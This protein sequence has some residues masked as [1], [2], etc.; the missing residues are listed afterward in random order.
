MND[1]KV[2]EQSP[3]IEEQ[4]PVT[5]APD[6]EQEDEQLSQPG[7]QDVVSREEF[8]RAVNELRGVQGKQ[9]KLEH[10]FSTQFERTARELGVE[11]TDEQ[12]LELRLR[13]LEAAPSVQ[14]PVV[15]GEEQVNED[16]AAPEVQ[17]MIDKAV[18]EALKITPT[19]ASAVAPSGGTT[20]S[21][22]IS[23]AEAAIELDN[24]RAT[25]PVSQQ[26]EQEITRTEELLQ[27]IAEEVD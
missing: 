6:S 16:S 27:I 9:D 8:D 20:P 22:Q 23:A 19:G 18:S 7:S 1:K 5:P 12:K 3:P 4:P 25:K 2:E 14:E 15:N 24:L 17:Q 26:T 13:K 11:L 10:Q 21:A